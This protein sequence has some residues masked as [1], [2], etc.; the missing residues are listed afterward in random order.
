M[1]NRWSQILTGAKQQATGFGADMLINELKTWGVLRINGIQNDMSE[2][3]SKILQPVA[4]F[5]DFDIT[6][7]QAYFLNPYEQLKDDI[8]EG[9]QEV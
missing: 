4:K 3:I 2:N 9:D 7:L 6:G 1:I 5:F 8:S